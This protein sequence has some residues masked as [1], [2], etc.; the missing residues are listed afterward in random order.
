MRFYS[1]MP[2]SGAGSL[3]RPAVPG[4]AALSRVVLWPARR[5]RPRR[6]SAASS[7]GA[8]TRPSSPSRSASRRTQ[9]VSGVRRLTRSLPS[10]QL[11]DGLARVVLGDPAAQRRQLQHHLDIVGRRPEQALVHVH[12]LGVAAAPRR[13]R[14]AR[15]RASTRSS[16]NSRTA[17]A[18]QAPG[19]QV[20]PALHDEQPH[21]VHVPLGGLV[22]ARDVVA[23]GA[24]AARA[25]R[26]P[27]SRASTRPAP[28]SSTCTATWALAAPAAPAAVSSLAIVRLQRR[29]VPATAPRRASA[30][31]PAARSPRPRPAAAAGRWTPPG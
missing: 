5:R 8:I 19:L 11:G 6:T 1:G 4:L 3:H 2:V 16:R 29:T 14:R 28:R 18:R 10:P 23:T 13:A 9:R 17:S 12:R 27:R 21:R 30:A 31:P 25:G 26:R 7:G 24:A 15:S 20:G 22:P